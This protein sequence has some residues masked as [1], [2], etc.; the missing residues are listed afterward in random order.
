[1]AIQ[2]WTW[3]GQVLRAVPCVGVR[4]IL[5]DPTGLSHQLVYVLDRGMKQKDGKKKVKT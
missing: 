4:K 3:G 5:V 2:R 1:M